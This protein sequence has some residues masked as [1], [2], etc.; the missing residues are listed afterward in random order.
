MNRSQKQLA[1]LLAILLLA[2]VVII[3]IWTTYAA[4]KQRQI[5]LSPAALPA[6]APTDRGTP[7]WPGF[8][9]EDGTFWQLTGLRDYPEGKQWWGGNRASVK[10]P[11]APSFMPTVNAPGMRVLELR[12]RATSIED[13]FKRR[14]RF[15]HPMSLFKGEPG[16]VLL[17]AD[18]AMPEAGC[19]PFFE[20]E[21]WPADG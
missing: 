16:I 6:T 14:F 5:S 21:G 12:F 11:Q 1:A 10:E 4:P 7:V 19:M 3:S 20:S 15:A 18:L 8:T 13:A 17:G 9:F 2:A